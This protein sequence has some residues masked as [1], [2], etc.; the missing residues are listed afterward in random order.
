MLFI[1]A[2]IDVRAAATMAPSDVEIATFVIAPSALVDDEKRFVRR[3]R[4]D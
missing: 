3:D 4:I 1:H 2:T